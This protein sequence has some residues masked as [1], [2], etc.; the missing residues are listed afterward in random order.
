MPPRLVRWCVMLRAHWLSAQSDNIGAVRR[1]HISGWFVCWGIRTA[2]I[3]R[4]MLPNTDG[5]KKGTTGGGT[6]CNTDGG[7]CWL[8]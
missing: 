8:Q 5:G 4:V 3:I 2:T 7:K 6:D 1:G